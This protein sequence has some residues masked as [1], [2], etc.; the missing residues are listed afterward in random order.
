L[1]ERQI[2]GQTVLAPVL[3]LA[4]LDSRDVRGGG[5]IQGRD[6]DLISGGDLVNV[7]TLRAT[8]DLNAY[9]AGSVLQGGLVEAGDALN[10]TARDDIRNAMG[11]QIRGDR[12]SLTALEGDVVNDRLSV[13]AGTSRDYRSYLDQ[14]GSISARDQLDIQAGRDV[15]NRGRL[16]SGADLSVTAGRDI[17]AGA[18]VDVSHWQDARGRDYQDSATT[19][20]STTTA[21]GDLTWQAG[22]DIAID[23]SQVLSGDDL[24]LAAGRDMAIVSGEDSDASRDVSRRQ[25]TTTDNVTQVG[26]T[27][28]SGGSAS[29]SA[30]GDIGLLASRVEA[31]E[32]LG[33][34]AGGDITLASAANSSESHTRKPNKTYDT[35]TVRQQGSELAAGTDLTVAAGGDLTLVASTA[36]A[37]DEA[38]LYAGGDVALLAANDEDYSR[39]EKNE[40]GGLFGGDKHR[41]DEVQDLRAQGCQIASNG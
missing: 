9:A 6:I 3:Y 12:V 41:L 29:L 39:Y 34:V 4:N 35:R 20:G 17:V 21:G 27:L 31:G 11:G 14:G 24:V 37:G 15:I 5:V 13:A 7:G 1:E 25:I 30:G 26:S 40:S 36:S 33:L 22:R 32:G 18:V 19:L 8:H 23:A 2:D 28:E 16:T 10:L 38:Y